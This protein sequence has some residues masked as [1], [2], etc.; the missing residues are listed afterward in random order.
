MSIA[1]LVAA[2]LCF[3]SS[4]LL[5]AQSTTAPTTEDLIHKI[6]SCLP[7]AVVVKGEPPSCT[8][9]L[10]RM[11]Q[12]HI[13][14]VSIA[15][16]HHGVVEWARGYGIAGPDN[17]PVTPETIFQAGSISKPVASMGALRLVQEGKLLLDADVNTKLTSWKVPPSDAAPGAVVTL[18]ELMTHTAGMT[19]HGFPGYAAGEPVPTLVQVLNGEKPANT[20]AVRIQTP[21]NTKW[22]YSGGGITI[23]QQLMIDVSHEPFPKLMHDTVL[24]PISMTHSTYQQPLPAALLPTAATPYDGQDKLIPGGAHT[25]PEMAAAGLW[26]TPSDLG[27]F[28]IENQQSL[29]G[30]ANHVLTQAMTKEMM[31]PGKGSWGLGI[32]IG[33]S[34]SNPYFQHD[35]DDA[36]FEAAFFGYENSGEGAAVMTNAQ[37]GTRLI[38]EVMSAIALAYGW[39]DFHPIE[40]TM[41]PLPPEALTSFTGTYEITNLHVVIAITV[42]NGQLMA[43]VN[44]QPKR[45]I[46]PESATRFFN[47]ESPVEFEFFP[48]D[49]GEITSLVAY[50]SGQQFKAMKT[51]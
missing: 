32:G 34:P 38:R 45:P 29:Q 4:P 12:L 1:R 22:N 24:A 48:N 40:R 43:Q 39:P 51:K 18:R 13:Q 11:Q 46:F 15:V 25:Y 6:E 36:G 20:P 37:S 26:T 31:T 27:R 19:V 7:P 28:I 10:M 21:P 33:G 16:V 23:M 8:P 9:L 42:E 3:V 47:R 2:V 17:K 44:D 14:G 5:I 41:I 49:K 35:G 30:K 50:Q